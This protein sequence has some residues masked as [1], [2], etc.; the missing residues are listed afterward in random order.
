M[1]TKRLFTVVALGL[2]LTLTALVA[3]SP[4]PEVARAASKE[5]FVEAGGTGGDCSQA[6]PC[7]LQTAL[8]QAVGADTV[9]AA[10]GTYTGTGAAVITVTES[11]ILYGGWDGTTATPPVRDPDAYVTTLDGERQRR[12]IYISSGISPTIDGFIITGGNGTGLGGGFINSSDAAGGIYSD[13]AAPIIQNNIITNNVASTQTDVRAFGG[14][15]YIS[16][17][18]TPAIVRQNQI[19]SNTAGVGI[20]LGDGG[21][22]FFHGPIQI[23]S[24]TFRGNAACV[25]CGQANGG[26]V[27]AGWT[28]ASAGARIAYNLFED[29]WADY[30][31]GVDI[32]WSAVEV[33]GNTLID[34][35]AARGGGIYG[36]YDKGSFINANRIISNT[37]YFGGGV[38]IYISLPSF[39]T[40]TNN[41][42]SQNQANIGG[43]MYAWSDWHIAVI[44]LTHNT[45]VDNGV[46]VLVGNHMT[47]TLINNIFVSHTLA[48][49]RTDTGSKVTVD[50]TLFWANDDDG[51]QGTNPVDGDPAFVSSNSGDYHIGPGSAALD[52]GLDAGVLTDIDGDTRPI[53]LGFDI[54]ADEFCRKVHLPLVL[55]N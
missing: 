21:G 52:A 24:N 49:S 1:H 42:L 46:G 34:N 7:A 3:L 30:G 33:S 51:L 47:A 11:V 9:Y 53:G 50:D 6:N 39:T 27:E 15:I 10:Q 36:Y 14:G 26:G 40:L 12:V 44:T 18:P 13:G 23:L 22:L 4:S 35:Q 19:L 16:A 54:G 5:W 31:G 2:A 8:A 55:R 29:N 20:H 43:G 48:I 25:A 45:V 28:E 38:G 37:A 41:V 17:A 32:V